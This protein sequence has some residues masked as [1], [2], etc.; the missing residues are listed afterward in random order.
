MQ[1][2]YIS[3]YTSFIKIIL[4]KLALAKGFNQVARF[5][6]TTANILNCY[7]LVFYLRK[8]YKKYFLYVRIKYIKSGTR[9]QLHTFICDLEKIFPTVIL[10]TTQ[11]HLKGLTID[12]INDEQTLYDF[13]KFI[14]LLKAPK[15]FYSKDTKIYKSFFNYIATN[16]TPIHLQITQ[17]TFLDLQ[18]YDLY[19]T[20]SDVKPYS[21]ELDDIY[22]Y[23]YSTKK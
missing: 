9:N 13:L 12:C 4:D 22:R 20:L 19:K 21:I 7:K 23:S 3:N 8:R 5:T 17:S 1:K 15:Y 11:G 10:D 14:A 18:N 2:R 6:L 16:K